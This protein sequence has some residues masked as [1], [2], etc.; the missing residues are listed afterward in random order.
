MNK[1]KIQALILTGIISVGALAP[2]EQ[3]AANELELIGTEVSQ[4]IQFKNT[5][6][7]KDNK[8]NKLVSN[9]SSLERLAVG[10]GNENIERLE[11]TGSSANPIHLKAKTLKGLNDIKAWL[12]NES[13][14][15]SYYRLSEFEEVD[16]NRTYKLHVFG[17]DKLVVYLNITVDASNTELTNVLDSIKEL[18]KVVDTQEGDGTKNSPRKLEVN[19]EGGLTE[20]IN[21]AYEEGYDFYRTGKTKLVDNNI[22]YEVYIV[23]ENGET[24]TY[25]NSGIYYMN[26][27]VHNTNTEVIDYLEEITILAPETPVDPDQPEEEQP[28][29]VAPETPDEDF[30][31]NT[32][33]GQDIVVESEAD[34]I[35]KAHV[36]KVNTKQ[37]LDKILEWLDSNMSYD[38]EENVVIDADANTTT[39]RINVFH[40]DMTVSYIDIKVSSDNNELIYLL[41]QVQVVLPPVE[42]EPETPEQPED[43]DNSDKEEKPGFEH[44]VVKIVNGNGQQDNPY[45]LTIKD[46]SIDVFNSFLND[47]SALNSQVV[48]V[49]TKD[50]FTLYTI[51]CNRVT[52]SDENVVYA[53]IKVEN[54][55]TGII[56][57]LN[58]FVKENTDKPVVLPDE[59]V[60]DEVVLDGT[61]M[62]DMT[63]EPEANNTTSNTSKPAT[64][65]PQTGSTAGVGHLL[66]GISS[67]LG[68]LG[69]RKRNKEK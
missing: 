24:T 32:D 58:E 17:L 48:S 28:P 30:D 20:L 26:L 55:R 19:T 36:L 49:E 13:I 46:V 16:G 21:W 69:L 53:T 44:E 18:I 35:N 51:K 12:D 22:I 63:V 10:A 11:G 15:I 47:L 62:D 67:L 33:I 29:V 14:N 9:A 57:A 45:E 54:S 5:S 66:L 40:H 60:K 8:L 64:K 2:A 59:S 42:E 37:G 68:G 61:H 27:V 41:E 3:A 56:N 65:L 25:T 43:G 39:Y 6:A 31:D 52:R 38:R 4:T 34:N 23:P 7:K 50:D 1:K